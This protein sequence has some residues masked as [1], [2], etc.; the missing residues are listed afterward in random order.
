MGWDARPPILRDPA[1]PITRV[2]CDLMTFLPRHRSVGR[3]ATLMSHGSPGFEPTLWS[4]VLL[5]GQE[6]NSERGRRAV[7]QL[8]EL[9]WLPVYTAFRRKGLSPPDAEDM[10]QGF[11]HHVLA[12]GFFG[13]ASPELGRFRNFLLGAVGHYFLN[14]RERL[15]AQRRGGRAE[16]IS[17]DT[18]AAETWLA[19]EPTASTD[20]AA[21]FDRAWAT[22]LLHH[23]LARLEAEQV[24]A[25]KS[26]AFAR[27]K[28]FLQRSAN[29]GE[30]DAVASELGLTKGAVAAA[31]HRLNARFGELVRQLVR[32]TVA[33][34]AL[35]DGEM[36]FLFAALHS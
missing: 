26:T 1:A 7:A 16:K 24:S 15:G 25:G 30:Y 12:N 17:I 14:E 5:A 22:T 33:D 36:R 21:A 32:D 28:V 29:P 27:L 13:R 23:A 18:A 20:A 9:Y 6:P 8:C 2:A 4:Q 11:F 3:G 35:A 19:A 10:A 31:V 34:P